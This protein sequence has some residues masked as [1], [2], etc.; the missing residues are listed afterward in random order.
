[1]RRVALAVLCAVT[2]GTVGT[3]GTTPAQAAGGTTLPFEGFGGMVVDAQH[4]HVFVSSG[5]GGS[6]ISVLNFSGAV[7]KT[8]TGEPG[9]SAMA[10]DGTNLYVLLANSAAVDVID[11][12]TLTETDSFS[13][14]LPGD[15]TQL[16]KL[17][18][19]LWFGTGECS[20]WGGKLTSLDVTDGT[21]NSYGSA[22]GARDFDCT[23][24]AA[25]D[26]APTTLLTYDMGLSPPTIYKYDISSGAPVLTDDQRMEASA[27]FRDIA[28]SADGTKMYT[29]SGAPYEIEVFN[30]SDLSKIGSLPTGAY[31]TAVEVAPDGT[32]A[33]GKDASYDP[34]VLLFPAGDST[35]EKS[36]DFGEGTQN[37]LLSGALK[38]SPD[39]EKVFVVTGG[40]REK[41]MFRVLAKNA[42][43]TSTSIEV[44][45]SKVRSGAQVTVTGKLSMEG[46]LA[47]QSLA[48]YKSVGGGSKTLVKRAK[49]TTG[50]KVTATL[51]VREKTAFTAVY[52][53]DGLHL[54]SKSRAKT[55]NV[56]IVTTARMSG[57]YDTKDKYRLYHYGDNVFLTAT[58]SPNFAGSPIK[59]VVQI[60]SGSSWNTVTAQEFALDGSSH[61]TM[62]LMNMP[63][64]EYREKAVFPAGTGHL[65]D[66]SPWQYVKVTA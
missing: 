20:S 38:L 7:V 2:V 22:E 17:G 57:F 28:F 45:K 31:P 64:G 65:G 3:V 53:G 43:P 44:S 9:A 6:S 1:M 23:G 61:F 51:R 47:G 4:D 54:P 14:P 35:P 37:N 12:T 11:T 52:E 46:A 50:G 30:V 56:L 40:F 39:Q 27:G 26:A 10:L 41:S 13:V 18:D 59:F 19:R 29:A 55:V 63:R 48:I 34:D 33:A 25:S 42:K 60:R 49:V 15:G 62:F 16:V 58:V 5:A 8:I 36:F 21:V 24:L 32:V 66:A